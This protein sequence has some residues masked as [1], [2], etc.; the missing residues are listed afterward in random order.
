MDE[1]QR[2]KSLLA[3]ALECIEPA[4][5]QADAELMNAAALANVRPIRIVPMDYESS[6]DGTHFKDGQFS[7]AAI[8]THWAHGRQAA[9]AALER[10]NSVM[11]G[12]KT[13]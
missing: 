13:L 6:Q 10:L 9:Q 12:R 11:S 3:Y 7:P 5:R 1:S 8:Q 2:L 4:R